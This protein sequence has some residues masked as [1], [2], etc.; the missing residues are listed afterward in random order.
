[1]ET[2]AHIG[3]KASVSHQNA[4]GTIPSGDALTYIGENGDPAKPLHYRK[5]NSDVFDPLR[6]GAAV[7]DEQLLG[8]EAE[9]EDIVEEGEERRE[10]K[11]RDED[12]YEAVLDDWKRSDFWG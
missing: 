4:C 10:R 2:Q 8:V 9:L 6:D 7:M 5:P 1:M 12:C 11:C 3:H